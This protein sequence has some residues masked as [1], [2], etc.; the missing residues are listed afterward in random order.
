MF[1]AVLLLLLAVGGRWAC[2]WVC[3]MGFIQD[4]MHRIP[5][6]K[7]FS[8]LPGERHLRKIKYILL[9]ALCLLIPLGI[10]PGA[11]TGASR[12]AVKLVGFSTVFLLSIPVYRPFCK[13]LCPFGVVLGAFNKVSVGRLEVTDFCNK[14]GLCRRK[15]PHGSYALCRPQPYGVHPLWG[16]HEVLPPGR[17]PTPYPRRKRTQMKSPKDGVNAGS[18]HLFHKIR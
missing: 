2:S 9:G 1:F 8:K 10:I 14:C 5:F 17:D 6:G 12:L 7:K 18:L 15:V 11:L 13:Y 16:V 3:P 4:L